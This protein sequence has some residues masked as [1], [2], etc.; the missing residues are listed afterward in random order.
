M[1]APYAP[2]LESAPDRRISPES[3]LTYGAGQRR[4]ET[5]PIRLAMINHYQ[6]ERRAGGTARQRGERERGQRPRRA[7][8]PHP[9]GGQP[10]PSLAA[11]VGGENSPPQKFYPQN[12]MG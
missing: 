5:G 11:G 12:K 10:H 8:P 9:T 2:N 1:V 6:L 4:T 7:R 3:S